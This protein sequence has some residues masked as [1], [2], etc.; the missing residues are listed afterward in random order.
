MGVLEETQLEIKYAS[1]L[2]DCGKIGVPEAILN[3]ERGL[4]E[5]AFKI[6]MRHPEWGRDVL[7]K[8]DLSQ[9]G[10]DRV[11]YGH[12]RFDGRGYPFG[13]EGERV[14]TATQIVSATPS[15]LTAHTA[16]SWARMNRSGS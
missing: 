12:E 2:H 7:P 1:W 3:A 16:G 4:A 6:V 15:A 13:L 9:I 10:Q 5:E 14:P 11:L 8:A